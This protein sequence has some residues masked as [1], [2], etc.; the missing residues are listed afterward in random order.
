MSPVRRDSPTAQHGALGRSYEL[1]LSL[2]AFSRDT[3]LS[4]RT[5]ILL[6]RLENVKRSA[7]CRHDG[8]SGACWA[9]AL[10]LSAGY[11]P[12]SSGVEDAAAHAIAEIKHVF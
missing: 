10:A 6:F 5:R 3:L 8:S 7:A 4:C 1:A 12:I 2:L 9:C 11:Y